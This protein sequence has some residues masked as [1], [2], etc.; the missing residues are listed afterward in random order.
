MGFN[1]L[2]SLRKACIHI[3]LPRPGHSSP[4]HF[5]MQPPVA[6]N[7]RHAHRYGHISTG[8]QSTQSY[9]ALPSY[10]MRKARFSP[11]FAR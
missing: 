3:C 1:A 5:E 7:A 4:C 10:M 9:G 6:G 8:W 2:R 11:G